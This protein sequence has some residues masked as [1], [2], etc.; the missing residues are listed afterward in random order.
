[1][2]IKEWLDSDEEPAAGLSVW[3]VPIYKKVWGSIKIVAYSAEEAQDEFC[4]MFQDDVDA[5][6]E[7]GDP[8]YSIE[9]CGQTEKVE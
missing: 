5:Q 6:A 4:N 3:S 9:W 8:E 2:G 1:M 7:W